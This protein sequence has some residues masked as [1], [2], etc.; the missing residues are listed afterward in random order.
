M[1]PLVASLYCSDTESTYD[2]PYVAIAGGYLEVSLGASCEGDDCPAEP[3]AADSVCLG[4]Y[5]LDAIWDGCGED[6][7]FC[8]EAF[9]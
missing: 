2:L 4:L 7:N 1:G 5:E 6:G 8:G 3:E 9:Q